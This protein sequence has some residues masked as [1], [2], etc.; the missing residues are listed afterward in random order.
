MTLNNF[1]THIVIAI[2]VILVGALVSA[3]GE[4][5]LAFG[6]AALLA[7][8]ELFVAALHVRS[9]K[10]AR[11]EMVI[12]AET[13]VAIGVFSLILGIVLAAAAMPT[14]RVTAGNVTFSD[15][16]P[17]LVS[18]GEG[19]FASA[20][21]PLLATALR[22]IEVLNYGSSTEA[23]T[24]QVAHVDVISLTR[25][26][27][28]LRAELKNATNDTVSYTNSVRS[29][30]EA[31]KELA[32]S[33]NDV[34]GA[35]PTALTAVSLDIAA[36]GPGVVA[37]FEATSGQIRT[38]ARQ[39]STALESTGASLKDLGTELT[40]GAKAMKNMTDEFNKLQTEAQATN[41]VLKRLQELLDTV[42]DFIRPDKT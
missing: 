40:S 23:S 18:F 7:Q 37:A 1:V 2:A 11:F 28:Q 12:A 8:V 22:Q 19:L 6:M 25:A 24:D 27:T 14:L 17:L 30:L 29:I 3:F 4:F 32:A 10:V 33:I 26:I 41:G 39:V 13:L 21:A 5:R 31:L 16:D 15:F 9:R 36:A 42:T 34:K 20:T 35:V 38:G